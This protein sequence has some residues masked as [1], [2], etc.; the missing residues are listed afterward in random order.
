ME[1]YS[2]FAISTIF[3]KDC[4]SEIQQK[5]HHDV[6]G[7][8]RQSAPIEAL[9]YN[10]QLASHPLYIINGTYGKRSS[11]HAQSMRVHAIPQSQR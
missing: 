8:N 1:I 5:H 11:K 2:H 10:K 7:N 3:C 9:F 4:I 6:V